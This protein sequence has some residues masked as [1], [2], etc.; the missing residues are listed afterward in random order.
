M[1]STSSPSFRQAVATNQANRCADS[2]CGRPRHRLGLWCKS[3]DGRARLYGH[4][5]A[6][7]LRPSLWAEERR[8][9]H[10]LLQANADHPGVVAALGYLSQWMSR[11]NANPASFKGAAEIDRLYRHGVQPESIVVEA[12]AFYLWSQGHQH[13]FPDQKAEDFARARAVYQLAPRA[14]RPVGN[15][16]RWG[17]PMTGRTSYAPRPRASGTAYVGRHLREALAAFVA[18]MSHSLENHQ[19]QQAALAQAMRAPLQVPDF[20]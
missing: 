13:A 2:S 16:A 19:R 11:A 7:P 15:A 12:A 18:N 17:Q 1:Y 6:K 5:Q 14:R 8:K 10:A 4:P 20:I 9:V 3:C